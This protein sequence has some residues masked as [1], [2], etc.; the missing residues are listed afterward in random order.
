VTHQTHTA[1]QYKAALQAF[2]QLVHVTAEVNR[3]D[4][5][6]HLDPRQ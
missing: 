1:D 5:S 2:P 3:C 6:A 4:E